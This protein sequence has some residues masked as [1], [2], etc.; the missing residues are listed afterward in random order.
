MIKNPQLML[1]SADKDIILNPNYQ[2]YI[3]QGTYN[4]VFLTYHEW[5]IGD[6]KGQWVI[7]YPL[8]NCALF[9]TDNNPCEPNHFNHIKQL[10]DKKNTYDAMIRFE[11]KLYWISTGATDAINIDMSHQTLKLFDDNLTLSNYSKEKIYRLMMIEV[12][13]IAPLIPEEFHIYLYCDEIADCSRGVRKWNRMN[14][15][16][17]AIQLNDFCWIA[18]YVGKTPA[19][20]EEIEIFLPKFYIKTGIIPIDACAANNILIFNG[21]AICVD[22]DF[23]IERG[24]LLSEKSLPKEDEHNWMDFWEKSRERGMSRSV[25]MIKTLLY[26]AE[27]I[28]YEYTKT[29]NLTEPLIHVL[30]FF[31]YQ[32]YPLSENMFSLLSI[33]TKHLVINA[34]TS[35]E[36]EYLLKIANGN[37]TT[38]VMYYIY[39][40]RV[41]LQT[42]IEQNPEYISDKN[43]NAQNIDGDTALM[44]AI[45]K[46]D[47]DTVNLLLNYTNI[48]LLPRNKMG[49]NALDLAYENY[50]NSQH[51]PIIQLILLKM[52]CYSHAVQKTLLTN[53]LNKKFENIYQFALLECPDF[54]SRLCNEGASKNNESSKTILF[55]VKIKDLLDSLYFDENLLYFKSKINRIFGG[56]CAIKELVKNL[57]NAKEKLYFTYN[58]EANDALLTFNDD[59]NTA[60]EACNAYF[61]N[62][63]DPTCSYSF[64]VRFLIA[65]D[66]QSRYLA[67]KQTMKNVI[68]PTK[69]NSSPRHPLSWP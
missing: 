12:D 63:P 60:I 10:I 15:N 43:L 68:P 52:C 61:T 25:S 9:I 56:G 58:K 2:E 5:D 33:I 49:D 30:H 41:N 69:E 65:D 51:E 55:L 27:K 20:D 67:F 7:K 22:P 24:S 39:D 64:F 50:K 11:D 40:T 66:F 37:L 48:S 21:E 17:N 6:Y 42:I 44:L 28:P 19:N 57:E 59:C 13:T 46:G 16:L 26:L 36:S 35:H 62:H 1:S 34:N 45:T 47:T 3:G 18:P 38:P 31:R 53:K 14:S 32:N 54:F 29:I 4:R 8:S 23:A